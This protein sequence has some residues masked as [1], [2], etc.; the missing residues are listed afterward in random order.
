MGTDAFVS[1][2]SEGNAF[3]H[4]FIPGL[5]DLIRTSNNSVVATVPITYGSNPGSL[6]FVLPVSDFQGLPGFA[7]LQGGGPLAFSV[8]VGNVNNATD[9]L[10]S[11]IFADAQLA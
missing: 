5:V 4:N 6:G 7:T 10:S 3:G 1:L 8:V 2:T 9:V 11:P